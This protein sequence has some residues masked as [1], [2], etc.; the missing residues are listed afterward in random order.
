M[1]QGLKDP[2]FTIQ[3]IYGHRKIWY[4]N[5]VN[6]SVNNVPVQ[7]ERQSYHRTLKLTF[8]KKNVSYHIF[9][10]TIWGGEVIDFVNVSYVSQDF[11]INFHPC[12]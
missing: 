9:L 7:Q 6:R 10:K 4:G 5:Q 8:V 12:K 1:Q 2:L 11:S 3:N